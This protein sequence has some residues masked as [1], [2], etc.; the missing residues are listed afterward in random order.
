MHYVKRTYLDNLDSVLIWPNAQ[1]RSQGFSEPRELASYLQVCLGK[2]TQ[3]ALLGGVYLANLLQCRLK[4]GRLATA[5]CVIM[6][7]G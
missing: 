5:D 3:E 2:S 4:S 7:V 1:L 6:Q